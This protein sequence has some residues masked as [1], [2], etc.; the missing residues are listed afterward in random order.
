MILAG[1]IGG[2]NVRLALFEGRKKKREQK[3]KSA[4][5]PNLETIV[6]EFLQEKVEKA[7]FGIAGPVKEGRCK[8]TNLPWIVDSSHLAKECRIPHVS[9]LNDLEANAY[10]LRALSSEEFFVLNKGDSDVKG[11]GALISA[12]TGLGEAGLYWD[13]AAL[14]PFAC[15]GGHV[16]FAPRNDLEWE[17][18]KYLEKKFGHVSYERVLSGPGIENLY[19]FLIDVKQEKPLSGNIS[20]LP[21]EI[22]KRAVEKTSPLCEKVLRWFSSIYGAEAGNAALKFLAISGVYLGG[23]IAPNILP[24]L[25]EK[26]FMEAFT[27]K[28]RFQKLLAQI[29]VKIVRNEDTALLGALEYALL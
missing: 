16:D 9:L 12:G 24:F 25:Q 3:Y 19:H 6:Q 15:E 23:G 22:S 17:L 18:Y 27:G 21:R 28:G 8:A 20:D 7:A 26:T 10:G 14:H 13:G 5:Y 29:P 11:N 2:T 1:D 4:S